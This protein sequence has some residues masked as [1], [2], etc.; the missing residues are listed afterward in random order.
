MVSIDQ[1]CL[2]GS[3][4]GVA[5]CDYCEHFFCER[6]RSIWAVWQRGVAA[7]KQYLFDYPPGHCAHSRA[8]EGADASL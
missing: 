2:C 4:K 1:C 7:V 3:T 5:W 6:E 8:T